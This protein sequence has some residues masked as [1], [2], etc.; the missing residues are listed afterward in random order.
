MTLLERDAYLEALHEALRR[1]AGGSG[2]LVFLGGEAGIGKSSLIEQ[3][4]HEARSRARTAVVSCDGVG[5][6]GPLGPLLDIAE[7]LGPEVEALLAQRA[8]RDAIFRAVLRAFRD[9]P[10]TI[11][12]VGE[13]AHWA[14]EATLELLRF[15]GRRIGGTRALV[16]IA[17]RNDELGPY[18]P[19]RR[20]LG[21]LANA[22]SVRRIDL[23]PLSMEAVYALVDG[24]GVDPVAL[25]ARTGGNPFF[26]NETIESGATGVPATVRDAVLARAARLSP[27]GRAVL[28]AAAIIGAT[29][30]PRLLGTVIGGPIADAV[31]E[32]LAVGMLR[33]ADEAIAF[34]HAIS[35]DAILASMSA[36]RQ[37]ALHQRV[38]EAMQQEP[39]SERDL[40]RLAY[41][42]EGAGDAAATVTFAGAAARQAAAFGSHREAAAQYARAVC[43]AASLPPEER[44]ALMESWSYECYLTGDLEQAIRI[45]REVVDRWRAAGNRL[46]QGDNTRWLSRFC[47]I[48]GQTADAHRFAIEAHDLLGPLPAGPELARAWS[49]LSQLRMLERDLP[50][51]IAWGERAIALATELGDEGVLTHALTNVGTARFMQ[52]DDA[53]RE[54]LEEA[55]RI[56]RRIGS[57]DDVSRPLTN[58]AWT[59]WTQ[60]ELDLAERYLEEGIAF[61]AERDLL[62]MELYQR[63]TRAAVWLERGRWED[64][65]REA[66]TIARLPT[67]VAPARIVALTCLGR[68]Q[69]V[70]REAATGALEAAAALAE[71]A[72]ELQ[73]LGPVTAA[74]AEA[75]WLAGDLS[76]MLDD[77][78][79]MFNQAMARGDRWTAGELGLW[80]SRAGEQVPTDDLAASYAREIAGEGV[81]AARLWAERGYPLESARALASTGG[82]ADLRDALAAFERIG[83]PADAARVIRLL[84]EMGARHIPRGPRAATRA[85]AERPPSGARSVQ[86]RLRQSPPLRIPFSRGACSPCRACGGVMPRRTWSC[87]PRLRAR[88]ATTRCPS[89]VRSPRTWH[90]R[91]RPGSSSSRASRPRRSPAGWIAPACG[92]TTSCRS[93][94]RPASASTT[95]PRFSSSTAVAA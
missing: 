54:M 91:P 32:C 89:I 23:P 65:R 59:A 8:P 33:P 13:D 74:R 10:E 3:F 7:A 18:H 11:V 2:E 1:V 66:A 55:A 68:L 48:A 36:P 50:G 64:A 43:F 72:G 6:P 73:R 19:L 39:H 44:L 15:L 28:D 30:D 5:M 49:N 90:G 82:E 42:A 62:A 76:P 38:L 94:S 61:T 29:I 31:E 34:R 67:A 51:A 47:W 25:H 20:V 85:N 52:Q 4:L 9:A 78:Q 79:T 14:D 71:R 56:A 24:T 22:P 86:S 84:R 63:A 80:L 37:R 57:D 95:P 88:R 21:D 70:H 35:R 81:V 93:R 60:R 69:S 58:L 40:A 17:Y 46:R 41:H 45:R 87:W 75:A 77:L 27:E 92:R 83:A 26:V 12:L 53:G 16:I